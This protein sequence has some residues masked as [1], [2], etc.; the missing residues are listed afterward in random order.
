M[1]RHLTVCLLAVTAAT[2]CAQAADPGAAEVVARFGDQVITSTDLEEQGDLRL[3]LIS[4]RQQ[5]YDV[6]RTHLE[7]M[8][9]DRLVDQAA[10]REGLTREQYLA[11]QVAG[12][13]PEPDEQRVSGVMSQYRS[14]LDPDPDKA[15]QQVVAA[16]KQQSE[17]MVQA[18]LKERLFREADVKIL[19]EPIRFEPQIEAFNPT[20]GGGPDA[21]VTLIEYT[22][23][24]CPFCNRV[25]PTLDEI[26][27]RYGDSV[28]H[29]FKQLPLPMHAQA[30]LAAEA[31]LCAAEQGRFWELHDW[32]FKNAS[33]I[34]RE[35]LAG[36]GQALGLDQEAFTACLD[37]RTRAD[38]VQRD[39]LE[40][41]RFGITGTPGFLV[42]GRVL[43][44]AVPMD[45]F[46]KL[47]DEELSRAG[48]EPPAA[49]AGGE[50]AEEPAPAS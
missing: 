39:A 50:E 26:V 9:F 10:E 23:F 11:E 34:S 44:G 7:Q 25:Q 32:L 17:Q 43:R 24:Q 22:D 38:L 49:T 6:T 4:V 45:D 12:K 20:R 33:R 42:N 16:L 19:L 13:V 36:Q 46:V 48:V 47:I 5:E 27:R 14:R 41:Q 1:F 28:R 30:Q 18:A 37:D 8:I 15:R 3:A 40:A 2:A 35:T 29:V 31:S 21:A